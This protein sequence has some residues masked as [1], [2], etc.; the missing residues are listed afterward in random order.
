M[1]DAYLLTRD[2]PEDPQP[3]TATGASTADGR[4]ATRQNA[5]DRLA[6][7]L[8]ADRETFDDEEA[9][10][11]ARFLVAAQER[12]VRQGLL[13][14]AERLGGPIEAAVVAGEGEFVLRRAIHRIWPRAEVIPVSERVS[15]EASL[16][17]CAHALAQ[18]A[19]NPARFLPKSPVMR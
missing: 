9:L 14:V 1:L 15:P 11:A 13:Q 18:I 4:A 10:T 16:S 2:I 7:M 6:R 17:A 8:C 12:R 5:R 3:P 19:E